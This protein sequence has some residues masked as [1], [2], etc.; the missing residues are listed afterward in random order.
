MF[1]GIIET[2]RWFGP[3]IANFRLLKTDTPIEFRKEFPMLQV[4]P[5][6]RAAYQDANPEQL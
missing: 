6:P 4:L 5:I 3:L 1:E 2:D